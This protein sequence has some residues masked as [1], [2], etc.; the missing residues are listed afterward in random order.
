MNFG[1]Q[2]ICVVPGD[3]TAEGVLPSL[4][5]SGG[6]G[7]IINM[8]QTGEFFASGMV[9]IS[10]LNIVGSATDGVALVGVECL[11][12]TSAVTTHAID[13]DLFAAGNVGEYRCEGGRFSGAYH[14]L[15]ADHCTINNASGP[16]SDG[17][18]APSNGVG[19][20]LRGC[21]FNATGLLATTINNEIRMHDTEFLLGTLQINFVNPG[22]SL[23]LDG[24]TNY[25]WQQATIVFGTTLTNGVV[26]LI[27]QGTAYYD[28]IPP[29]VG[30]GTNDYNPTGF[31]TATNI[32]QANAG[33]ANITGLAAPS[34]GLRIDYN[35]RKTFINTGSGALI[36]NHD[37]ISSS[38]VNRLTIPGNLDLYLEVGEQVTFVY[39]LNTS[40]WRA[41]IVTLPRIGSVSDVQTTSSPTTNL[42]TTSVLV[43]VDSN[44]GART[45][46][47]PAAPSSNQTVIVKDRDGNASVNNITIGNNGNPIDSNNGNITLA[48][49]NGSVTL[50]WTNDLSLFGAWRII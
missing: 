32:Y 18:G 34:V 20:L 41:M 8:G 48:A 16:L 27:N 6:S 3:Y 21:A 25:L 19:T 5:V 22:G 43:L 39:D 17:L 30:L 38:A 42:G 36:F 9:R 14:S 45:V 44:N 23:L 13:C 24:F 29:L 46:N 15:I 7:A 1:A 49:N 4:N 47:L 11:N 2:R 12:I 50:G 35:F 33:S 31:A 28:I 37:S 40:R 10:A 26:A